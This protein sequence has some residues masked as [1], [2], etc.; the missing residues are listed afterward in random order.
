M[1]LTVDERPV[2]VSLP[3]IERAVLRKSKLPHL[4]KGKLVMGQDKSDAAIKDK[5]ESKK[6]V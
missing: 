5:G 2:N 1:D 6:S 4:E 3:R